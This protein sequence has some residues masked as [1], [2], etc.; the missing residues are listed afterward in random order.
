MIA[1]L[2]LT[3]TLLILTLPALA[4]ESNLHPSPSLAPESHLASPPTLAVEP[5]LAPLP[6]TAVDP[7][8]APKPT[9][10][11]GPSLDPTPTPALAAAPDN[12]IHRY[13]YCATP[14]GAQPKG[15]SGQALLVFDIDNHFKFVR[16]IPNPHFNFGVRGLTGCLATHSLYYSTTDRRLG[17]F[18]LES[19]QVLWENLYSGGCDRSSV[20]PDGSRIYAPTGWWEKSP[21]SGF[22]IIDGSTGAELQRLT[23]GQNAHNSLVSPDG[24]RLFLGTTTTLSVFDITHPTDPQKPTLLKSIP[25]V[26]ESGVFPFTVNHQLSLA[27]VCLGSHVG[28]DVVDL[29]Q[30]KPIHRV[31]A[32][33]SPIPH[34]THGIAL[35]PD[36]S[37]IWISDQDGKK[38]F[39]FDSTTIPP[40]PKGSLN[41]STTGHG[42][43]NFSLDGQYAWCH[44]PEIF[45]AKT[46]EPYATLQDENGQP[47]STSKLIEVHFKNHKVIQIS[48]EFGLGRP[49]P[50][51]TP[52]P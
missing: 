36:Q 4:T 17:K 26:G 2:L 20:S 40:T 44:T 9:T 28:F 49:T 18:D 46:K 38:L 12:R 52:T 34:R 50:T 41:L 7:A 3:L 32:S 10:A 11:P 1:R 43:V 48:S 16:R 13:L 37:E 42:W 21:Q 8:L 31:L 19:D 30:G 35:T 47:F 29:L 33:T 6:S 45:N 51:P 27:F 22:V 5:A 24:S 25:N 14:D 15:G 39:I 23:V